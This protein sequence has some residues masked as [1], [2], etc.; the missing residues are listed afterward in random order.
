M[1]LHAIIYWIAIVNNIIPFME[2]NYNVSTDANDRA[3]AGLSMGGMTATNV[4]F[5][6]PEEF[7]YV[8]VFSGSD[9][10]FDTS[11]V[12]FKAVDDTTILIGG[13][14]Y[15]FGLVPGYYI[16]EDEEDWFTVSALK[17]ILEENDVDYGWAEAYGDHDWNTWPQLIKVFAEEYLWK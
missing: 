17:A 3:F 2:E 16:S 15:D 8:G 11:T 10:A 9:G 14:I 13:G 5:R 1:W 7:G 12:D 6:A 4:L